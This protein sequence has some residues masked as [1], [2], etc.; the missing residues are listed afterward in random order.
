MPGLEGVLGF[1]AL[2]LSGARDTG[3]VHGEAA[4]EGALDLAQLEQ[5][6]PLEGL[7]SA[8]RSGQGHELLPPMPIPAYRNLSDEELRAGHAYLRTIPPRAGA[9]STA[10]GLRQ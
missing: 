7:P 1:N 10:A 8:W 3:A 4:T 6:G 9:H 5:R 2:Q